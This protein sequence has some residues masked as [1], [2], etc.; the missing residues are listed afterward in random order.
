MAVLAT[1][2]VVELGDDSIPTINSGC[3]GYNG[4]TMKKTSAAGAAVY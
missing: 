3:G 4:A 2:I 1:I